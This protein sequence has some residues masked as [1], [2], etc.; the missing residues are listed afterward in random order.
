[1][2]QNIDE[3]LCPITKIALKNIGCQIE[4]S[5]NVLLLGKNNEILAK[6]NSK[7]KIDLFFCV[8]A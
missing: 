2:F 3:L 8:E 5:G 6:M 7:A 1:M 4:Y